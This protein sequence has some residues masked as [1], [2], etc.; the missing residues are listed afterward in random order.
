MKNKTLLFKVKKYSLFLIL[1]LISIS[2][3]NK[4]NSDSGSFTQTSRYKKQVNSITY[5][6]P[7]SLDTSICQKLI[8]KCE[9]AIRSNLKLIGENS[10]K[11]SID[12]EF[13]MNR[14]EML[15]YTG[16]GASGMSFPERK[17]MFSIANEKEAPI[18][19]ELLHMLAMLKWGEPHQTS[20][21]M[22]EG[23]A[24]FSENNCNNFNVEQIYCYFLSKSML[25]PIDSLATNFYGQP[26]MIAYHQSAY[27]VQ[28]LLTNYGITKFKALWKNGLSNFAEIYGLPIS[29]VMPLIDE[30]AKSHYPK[31][32]NINWEEFKK[33]CN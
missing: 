19:H 20:I 31:T 3:F 1:I 10:F 26:D 32:P 23:L 22:N 7:S 13:L 18:I 6:F 12:I 33:G 4:K 30:A 11:D 16:M 29:Q 14:K 9:N 24:T 27:L 15:K 17:T 25:I 21:W 8:V 2:C 28:F 5:Y